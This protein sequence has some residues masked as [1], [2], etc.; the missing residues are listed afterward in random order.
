MRYSQFMTIG[1]FLNHLNPF[2]GQPPTRTTAAV[3][4]SPRESFRLS[5]RSSLQ[6]AAWSIAR[7]EMDRA[8]CKECTPRPLPLPQ[9]PETAPQPAATGLSYPCGLQQMAWNIAHDSLKDSP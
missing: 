2:R 7:E 3:D 4:M 8:A 9:A 6:E 1:N 5:G